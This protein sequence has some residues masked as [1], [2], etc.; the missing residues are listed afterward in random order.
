[1]KTQLMF[2]I[3]TPHTGTICLLN[4][5]YRCHFTVLHKEN[6]MV[7]TALNKVHKIG[8]QHSTPWIQ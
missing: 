4:K 1:M 8:Y 3:H 2:D 5:C 7:M 6:E